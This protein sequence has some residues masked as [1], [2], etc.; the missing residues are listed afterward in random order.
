[1]KPYLAKLDRARLK[2]Y[3]H[4]QIDADLSEIYL[5]NNEERIKVLS[6]KVFDCIDTNNS[7]FIERS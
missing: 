4:N 2:I 7:G 5:C 6:D 3:N 1:M